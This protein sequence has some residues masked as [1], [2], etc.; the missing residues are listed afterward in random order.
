MNL[1]KSRIPKLRNLIASKQ[2]KSINGSFVERSKKTRNKKRKKFQAER[3]KQG[4]KKS[5]KRR[6]KDKTGSI[7][8]SEPGS[9]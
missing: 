2:R 4:V 1:V 3:L 9:R 8:P 7:D 6:Q 5:R